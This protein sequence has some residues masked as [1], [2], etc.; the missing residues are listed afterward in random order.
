[1]FQDSEIINLAM[2]FASILIFIFI[3]IEIEFP[4]LRFIY[5]GFALLFSG[6]LFTIIESVLWGEFF[7]L[8][9]HL[10]YALSGLSFAAGCWSIIQRSEHERDKSK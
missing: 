7:N 1:M 2:G 4:K 8:L 9:E 6:Y 10:S 5:V 3:F